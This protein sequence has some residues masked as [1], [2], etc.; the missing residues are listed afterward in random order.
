VKAYT[1]NVRRIKLDIPAHV[2]S[3]CLITEEFAEELGT[4]GIKGHL[5]YGEI[6]E[7]IAG[8]RLRLIEAI[9]VTEATHDK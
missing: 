9:T 6:E 2:R 7:L 5:L 4:E 8:I 3:P 1:I